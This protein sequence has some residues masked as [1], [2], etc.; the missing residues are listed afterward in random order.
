MSD[1]LTAALHRAADETNDARDHDELH[2]AAMVVWFA[3]NDENV[4]ADRYIGRW[5]DGLRKRHNL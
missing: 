5:I 4:L 3:Q 1:Q 2:A